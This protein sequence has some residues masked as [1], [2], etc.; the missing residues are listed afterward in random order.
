MAPSPPLGRADL[1]A[2]VAQA[3]SAAA[4][5]APA[6]EAAGALAGRRFSLRLP[7]GCAG[8]ASDTW[9]GFE[10]D[11]RREA[12]R[13]SARPEAWTDQ[14]WVRTLVATDGTESIAGFWLR[15]PWMLTETCPSVAPVADAGGGEETVG[16]AQV[17]EAGGSR[18]P[19]RGGR[20]YQATEKLGREPP[21]GRGGFRLVL[22]GRVASPEAR[23][24]I[25][26]L[27]PSAD[28]RP[29]CLVMVEIDRVAF[30]DANG[31]RIAEWTS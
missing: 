11:E 28:Q 25:R 21:P 29:V 3:A 10:Y 20:A 7:F 4:A 2:A 27:A 23:G 1:L 14:P 16:L 8:P 15:R 22:E 6:P 12:L 5:G 13:L 17:F 26:C 30:E 19:R 18:V 31:R 24:P 9:A